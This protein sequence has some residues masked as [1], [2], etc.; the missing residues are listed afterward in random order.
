MK[1]TLENHPLWNYVHD[2]LKELLKQTFLLMKLVERDEKELSPGSRKFHDYAFVI[3][4]AAKAYEGFL[5]TLFH[6]MGFISDEEYFGKRFR[7]GK[8]LNPAL[9]NHLREKESVY[10]KLT[11]FCQGNELP[12]ALWE[13]WK[14]GRNL[15]FHWFPNEKNAIDFLEAKNIFQEITDTMDLAFEECKINKE[16]D[17]A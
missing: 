13:T 6:D 2:D 16:S 11:S 3:F 17:N 14:K 10:D 4:P 5:K 8:A 15:L 7:I 9:E 1:I 12:N